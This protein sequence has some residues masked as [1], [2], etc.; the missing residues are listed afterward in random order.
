MNLQALLF[1]VC[2]VAILVAFIYFIARVARRFNGKVAQRTYS[3]IEG[4]IIAGILLGVVGMFQPWV[5]FAYKA[6][7]NVLL[8]STL[9]YIVWS[10]VTPKSA[11]NGE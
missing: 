9:A 4:A 11:H 3:A 10:H 5:H 7:F 2:F 6:G 8:L 1:I